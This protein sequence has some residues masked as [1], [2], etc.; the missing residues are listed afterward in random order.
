M[1]RRACADAKRV[2]GRRKSP[3][4]GTLRC[5]VGQRGRVSPHESD[6]AAFRTPS[7]SFARVCDGTPRLANVKRARGQTRAS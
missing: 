4:V 7:S 3:A 1:A 6:G 5:N 2:L